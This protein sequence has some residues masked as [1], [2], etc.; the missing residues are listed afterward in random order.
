LG[1]KI[2]EEE[3]EITAKRSA[4]EEEGRGA[5]APEAKLAERGSPSLES[6]VGLV[7]EAHAP[8]ALCKT[9]V[10]EPELCCHLLL[11]R[12]PSMDKPHEGI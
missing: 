3:E 2:P 5:S 6:W 12:W 10:N 9:A 8:M 4:G 1:Q 11:S 7:A